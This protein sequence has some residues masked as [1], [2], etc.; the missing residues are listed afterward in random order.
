MLESRRSRQ[1][2]GGGAPL[3]PP[4]KSAPVSGKPEFN[5]SLA[6]G[7]ICSLSS[8]EWIQCENKEGTNSALNT[9]NLW[10]RTFF[11]SVHLET[12]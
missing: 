2:W 10:G 12:F 11:F 5:P 7:W 3:Y 6:A 8:Y 9:V 4:P 1:G